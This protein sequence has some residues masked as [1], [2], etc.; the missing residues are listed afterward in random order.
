[1]KTASAA[2]PWRRRHATSRAERDGTIRLN[3]PSFHIWA[4]VVLLATSL[5]LIA[6]GL[7]APLLAQS[8]AANI[9]E[10][11]AIIGPIT[12][13]YLELAIQDAETHR[14]RS[15]RNHP[16]HPRRPAQLHARHGG[17]HP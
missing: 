6:I 4:R 17:G 13:R 10:M 1:M 3:R 11:D 16:R 14:G 15:R 8:R 5:L 9:V 7:A 12:E 2:T